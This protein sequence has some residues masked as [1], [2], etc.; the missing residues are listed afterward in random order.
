MTF[1][2]V[3]D[4]NFHSKEIEVLLVSELQ[5]NGAPMGLGT[6]LALIYGD[7]WRDFGLIVSTQ[8]GRDVLTCQYWMVQHLCRLSIWAFRADN[9]TI[10]HKLRGAKSLFKNQL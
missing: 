1:P 2:L 9:G 8:K 3:N 5:V 6:V 7:F 10:L 4:L